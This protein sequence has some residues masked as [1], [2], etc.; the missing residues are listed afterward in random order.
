MDNEDMKTRFVNAPSRSRWL[1]LAAALALQGGTAGAV[2]GMW[3]PEQLPVIEGHMRQLGLEMPAGSLTDL[4]GFPFGAVISL[5]GCTASFVSPEGLVV[6]NHHCARGSVQYNSTPE[7]NYLADGFVARSN[8]E[9]LRAAPGTR[10][11]VTTKLTDVTAQVNGG[12]PADMPPRERYQ[13]MDDRKKQLVAAC[14]APGGLRCLVASFHGGVQFTLVERLEIRDVR[15]VYAPGDNVGKYGGDIDN[16]MWPRHTGDFSFY[17]AYVAPDGKPAGYSKDNVPFRPK[18]FLKVSRS[19]L[20]DG[21]FIMVAGYPGRTNRYARLSEVEHTFGWYYP[22]MEKFLGE[23]IGTIEKAAPEGSD[24]RFK[25]EARLAGLNNFMKNLGGQMEGARRVGLAERRGQREVALLDW[26]A[27][28]HGRTYY[29]RTISRLEDVIADRNRD[30][31]EQFWFNYAVRP[32]LLAAAHEL[33]RLSRERQKPDAEREPGYQERDLRFIRERM[34]AIERRYDPAVDRAEWLLFLQGYLSQPAAQRVA[35]LDDA[36]KLPEQFDRAAVEALLE[37]Y[38]RDTRLGDVATRLAWMD[39][40]PAEFEGS[41]DPFIRLAVALYAYRLAD[42]EADK[43]R[44]G[45]MEASRPDYMKTLIA[46][47]TAQGNPVYP[48]ANGTLRV[49]YGTVFGGSPRDGIVYEPFTRLEGIVEKDTGIAPFDAPPALLEKVAAKDYG[50]YALQ[51]IGSVPVNFLSDLDTTGGNSGS[52]TL[53]AQ[54]NL[55]GLLFD[56]TLE[57]VNSD[58]DFDPR[59]TRSIHVDTRYMLWVMEKVDDARHLV[60]EM[61]L[62]TTR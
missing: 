25:Y 18:H 14:E 36:L 6:T 58:W 4:T 16:W 3:T 38:Y 45:R 24:A 48:D 42:E 19:G 40:S 50:G 51:S 31:R 43:A 9:E 35:V 53:D 12:L 34:E 2:E 55:V 1:P 17:R 60:E 21:D 59:T 44:N 5:G 57:S 62:T 22:R 47:N 30:A 11:Y 61:T 52:P 8:A 15:L 20:Q 39:N 13:T 28:R 46:W 7:R 37:P 10:V 26:V 23:W 27:T 41:D 33:Y 32:Q 49:T 56:G 54:G 29:R